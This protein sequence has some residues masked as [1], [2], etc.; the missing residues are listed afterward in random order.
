MR[1]FKPANTLPCPNSSA[2]SSAPEAMACTL[3]TQRTRP[4]T[5]RT[6]VSRFVRLCGWRHQHYTKQQ[7]QFGNVRSRQGFRH[8]ILCWCMS[9]GTCYTGN[10]THRLAPVHNIARSTR[11]ITTCGAGALSL[12]IWQHPAPTTLSAQICSS[13]DISTF[14]IAAIT[15]TGHCVL[16]RCHECATSA[17]LSLGQSCPQSHAHC[18]RPSCGQLHHLQ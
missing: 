4:V 13:V 17:P 2:C 6:K 10:K 18:I 5:W 14:K 11:K 1:R 3:S 15:F 7:C 9:N 8:S 12:A 16:Q